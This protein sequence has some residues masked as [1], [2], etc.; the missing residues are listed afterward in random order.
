MWTGINTDSQSHTQHLVSF[1]LKTGTFHCR[2][3]LESF[4]VPK[5]PQQSRHTNWI[6]SGIKIPI[7]PGCSSLWQLQTGMSKK[8]FSSR[9]STYGTRFPCRAEASPGSSWI[10]LQVPAGIAIPKLPGLMVS[11]TVSITT[12]RPKP[13]FLGSSAISL[14]AG[15][16]RQ[17]LTKS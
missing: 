12:P 15:T 1:Q 8:W 17:P 9:P 16:I 2:W 7:R 10:F 4:L 14:W 13:N 3:P 6:K 5:G 11:L